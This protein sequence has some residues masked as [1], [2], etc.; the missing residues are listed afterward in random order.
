MQG[1]A[2]LPAK[3]LEQIEIKVGQPPRTPSP[4][5]ATRERS[6]MIPSP[7]TLSSEEVGR[8]LHDICCSVQESLDV[9]HS[10][11]TI[12]ERQMQL[13][14]TVLDELAKDVKDG[15]SD[16]FQIQR[17]PREIG[18]E[19]GDQ[20]AQE[21]NFSQ[22]FQ[23]VRIDSTKKS[24]Y[25]ML[26]QAAEQMAIAQRE[27]KAIHTRIHFE[28]ENVRKRQHL[29]EQY[30]TFH[31]SMSWTK[32]SP[33]GQKTHQQRLYAQEADVLS[34]RAAVDVLDMDLRM[35][36][37]DLEAREQRLASEQAKQSNARKA[38]L[39]QKANVEHDLALRQQQQQQLLDSQQQRV[40]LAEEANKTQERSLRDSSAEL[41]HMQRRIAVNEET[42]RAKTLELAK[43]EEKLQEDAK[44]LAAA[45]HLVKSKLDQAADELGRA[46]A[47]GRTAQGMMDELEDM[48]INLERGHANAGGS[49]GRL[50]FIK[51]EAGI[52]GDSTGALAT[53]GRSLV[54]ITGKGGQERP[55]KERL[56]EWETSRVAFADQG[57][58][59]VGKGAD[60]GSAASFG[61]AAREA[62]RQAENGFD[63]VERVLTTLESIVNTH[64]GSLRGDVSP[65]RK[66]GSMR[67]ERDRDLQTRPYSRA[68]SP[69][70]P[71]TAN[72]SGSQA[73]VRWRCPAPT[74]IHGPLHTSPGRASSVSQS[75]IVPQG[76]AGRSHTWHQRAAF[77]TE[78]FRS[79]MQ[80]LADMRHYHR[81]NEVAQALAAHV[82]LLQDR[83]L[84]IRELSS[85]VG[86]LS[87]SLREHGGQKEKAE[88]E[89]ELERDRERLLEWEQERAREK[90]D[91]A[92]ARREF[93]QRE[94]ALSEEHDHLQ[95]QA[96][97]QLAEL[98]EMRSSHQGEVTALKAEMERVQLELEAARRELGSS[99]KASQEQVGVWCRGGLQ[100]SCTST[101]F[102]QVS[103]S[104]EACL[105]R[106]SCL[107]RD[108]LYN[109]N[110]Q[111][112]PIPSRWQRE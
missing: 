96:N 73:A 75:A 40:R 47:K 61:H 38:N 43:M 31:T 91:L 46:H 7:L 60:S 35:K 82:Q 8:V 108:T 88:E 109:P 34:R 2:R 56:E 77:L 105:V 80:M 67:I 79:S 19:C 23:Q 36:L 18:A 5:K 83:D 14:V 26:R 81:E 39:E 111:H 78:R 29:L 65:P 64:D 69:S 63:V 54:P 57:T 6:E 76:L 49:T 99:R 72:D 37:Q 12:E 62:Q 4:R 33:A 17:R 44:K 22:A 112:E 89:R 84:E 70:S 21:V 87:A 53:S 20:V 51:H 94:S 28:R 48:L 9:A 101:L 93:E 1:N 68:H 106:H 86:H 11:V 13:H 85:Q 90:S 15:L 92:A 58:P 10:K 102:V 107:S 110:P 95:R 74:L 103:S 24:V 97:R 98:E 59:H 71:P 45:E 32:M 3:T 100:C 42:L 30:I 66:G 104:L 52:A 16:L 27:L 55:A 25:K 41:Q 50:R